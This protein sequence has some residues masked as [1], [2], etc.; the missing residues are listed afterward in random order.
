MPHRSAAPFLGHPPIFP[1]HPTSICSLF[2]LALSWRH[3][4]QSLSDMTSG[5]VL[6]AKERV[7]ARRCPRQPPPCA[8]EHGIS[9]R[10]GG[11]REAARAEAGFVLPRD[12]S[13]GFSRGRA[14][15]A[16]ETCADRGPRTGP[17]QCMT[18]VS[19]L[20]GTASAVTEPQCLKRPRR[21]G[22][23]TSDPA[24]APDMRPPSRNTNPGALP[25]TA[26]AVFERGGDG[27]LGIL[28]RAATITPPPAPAPFPAAPPPPPRNPPAP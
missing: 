2:V 15:G 5:F 18:A 11:L 21:N 20:R 14:I 19:A 7:P 22:S 26:P 24:G 13:S 9:G 27:M 17:K 16:G 12:G 1:A 6:F 23:R 3:S 8:C 25:L 28:W 10:G 4:E